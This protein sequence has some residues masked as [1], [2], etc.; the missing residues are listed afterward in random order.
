[1]PR[2]AQNAWIPATKERE[3][4]MKKSHQGRKATQVG[5]ADAEDFEREA[6]KWVKFGKWMQGKRMDLRMTQ[7]EAGR[8]AGLS[9]V[10]WSRIEGGEATKFTTIPRIARALGYITSDQIEQ[11]YRLAGFSLDQEPMEIPASLRH[12]DELPKE[13]QEDIARQVQRAYEHEQLKKEKRGK[14]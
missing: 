13:I 9:R 2:R 5:R 4:K 3:P 10:Q 11:V 12:F 7:R 14:K 6:E 1:M 8:K